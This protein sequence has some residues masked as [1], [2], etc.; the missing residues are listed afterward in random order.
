MV[1][2]SKGDHAWRTSHADADTRIQAIH[3]CILIIHIYTYHTYIYFYIH[4]ARIITID[5]RENDVYEAED[6]TS[7]FP[8]VQSAM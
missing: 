5:I 8:E 3:A 1:G 7:G 2:R 6:T 4:A